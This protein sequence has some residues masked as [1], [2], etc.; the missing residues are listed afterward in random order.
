LQGEALGIW[1]KKKVAAKVQRAC[2][3][4]DRGI[5]AI[6]GGGRTGKE[7]HRRK[8]MVMGTSEMKV[9]KKSVTV[10]VL[11][12]P[13]GKEKKIPRDEKYEKKTPKAERER[14]RGMVGKNERKGL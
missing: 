14:F 10:S 13:Q 7:V 12:F 6:K 3:N 8:G 4:H 5:N 1:E 2:P 9:E 11:D